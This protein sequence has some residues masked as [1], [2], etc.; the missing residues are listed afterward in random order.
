MASHLEALHIELAEHITTFLKLSD[1]ASL[2]LTSRTMDH[3]ASHG[4]FTTFFRRKE[5]VLT[6]GALQEMVRLTSQGRLGRYLQHCT[7]T[8]VV[9]R[10]G[11]AADEDIED[12]GSLLAE[13]FLNL[14]KHSPRHGLAS[15]CLCV[16]AG[17]KDGDRK[18]SEPEDSP[19]W[20][21]VWASAL[22]TF[23][24]TMAALSESQLSVAEHLDIFG[25][26]AGCSLACDAFLLFAQ[27]PASKNVLGSLKSLTVS[28][29]APCKATDTSRSYSAVTEAENQAQSSHSI[30][31]LHSMMRASEIML[32]LESVDLHWYN[33]GDSASTLPALAASGHNDKTSLAF[34]HL[35][36][37]SLRGIYVS[38]VDLLQFFE[39]AQP[40]TVTLAN[41]HLVSGTYSSIWK[42]LTDVESPVTCY[43]LDDV[44][45]T[46][47]VHFDAP[48]K[49]KFPSSNALV[50]PTSLTRQGSHVKEE[51]R[52][53]SVPGRTL[54]S[55]AVMRW[56]KARI[57]EFG[58]PSH[59]YKLGSE[60]TP[61][62]KA[63]TDDQT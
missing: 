8:G 15:L 46:R 35:K 50:G 11:S 26:T 47:L 43:H 55:P 2:R 9:C 58:P 29:S 5:V 12:L 25:S 57:Q 1:I 30:L 44:W 38:E 22:R 7:I 63:D 31:I 24:L 56:R 59:H 13:A 16:T 49:P 41:V 6:T 27:Q 33:L 18:L 21:S 23:N 62:R 61:H 37:C 39:A 10:K 28:L 40:S 32:K 51:I 3:K 36:E 52:C 34:P 14:K 19:A 42:F 4:S 20:R 48:G 53:R 60:K 54:G 45:D 17:S